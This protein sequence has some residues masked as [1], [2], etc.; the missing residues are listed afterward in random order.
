[1]MDWLTNWMMREGPG[2]PKDAPKRTGLMLLGEI[3]VREAWELFKLNLLVALFSLPIVTAPAAHTAGLRVAASM[4]RDENVYLWRDYRA[5]FRET[6]L[7]ATVVG[8]GALAVVGLGLYAVFVW[9]RLALTNP[10]YAAPAAACLAATLFVIMTG[11]HLLL[12]VAVSDRKL[13]RLVPLA[14]LASLGWPLPMLG[15]L[16]FAAAL[17]ALHALFYPVSLFMPA[18][19]NFSLAVL[20]IAFAG[21]PAT[22]RLLASQAASRPAR[23]GDA[24]TRRLASAAG[25]NHRQN[26]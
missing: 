11:C 18:V 23:D 2:I 16:V 20:G 4:V 24:Q 26:H 14:A 10:F 3:V 5:A 1:M 6:F 8:F 7:R 9:G 13:A 12:L 25:R 21:L 17:W 15:A 22:T 19:A